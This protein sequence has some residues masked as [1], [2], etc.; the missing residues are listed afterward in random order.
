VSLVPRELLQQPGTTSANSADAL[1]IVSD[2]RRVSYWLAG[3]GD[4]GLARQELQLATSDDTSNLP[5]NIADEASLVIAPE[6]KSLTFSYFDGT[7]W[8]D[9]WDGTQPGS[10]GVTPMGPPLAVAIT[11]GIAP[12]GFDGSSG[13]A[14]KLKTFRHVVAIPT[15]NFGVSQ[16]TTGMTT[17]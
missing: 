7:D 12:P 6:V 8:Q 10:D 1:P 9:S 3:N 14:P 16:S 11:I 17:P 15:A 13:A 4:G 2:V 5:P